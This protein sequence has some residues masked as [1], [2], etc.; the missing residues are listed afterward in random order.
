MSGEGRCSQLPITVRMLSVTRVLRVRTFA[1]SAPNTGEPQQSCHLQYFCRRPV[2]LLKARSYSCEG[3]SSSFHY[4]EASTCHTQPPH[5]HSLKC[6]ATTEATRG[7]KGNKNLYRNTRYGC[8]GS[9][10]QQQR[11]AGAARWL[12]I[13]SGSWHWQCTACTS[14]IVV[15]DGVWLWGFWMPVCV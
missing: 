14:S 5:S 12:H 6:C 1:P 7:E 13:D 15:T 11:F 9:A 2:S 8:A 3:F 10:E 4:T